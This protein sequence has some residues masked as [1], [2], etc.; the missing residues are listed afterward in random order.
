LFAFYL[1]DDF[2]VHPRVMI[3]AGLRY[4]FTTMPID[5]YG[6]DSALPNLSDR[7]PTTG[8]LYRN[9]TY[10]NISP[11]IGWHGMSS[12]PARRPFAAATA[13]TSI[14]TINRT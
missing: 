1:Q 8:Q 6:R 2:K 7:A 11:R 13:C 10:K 14:P 4:E 3:N 9:P 5:L 12:V